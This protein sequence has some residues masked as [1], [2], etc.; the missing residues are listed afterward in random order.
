MISRFISKIT[1]LMI[2]FCFQLSF[3]QDVTVDFEGRISNDN[4]SL[5]EAI[6]QVI[7]NGKVLT[8]FKTDK[9]GSYNVYLP[10]GG[11]YIISV[12]KNDYVKKYFS[13]STTGIPPEKAKN[14]FP[15]IEADVDL[16]K[17][18]EGVDY[19]LFDQPVNKYFYNSKRDNIDYD[20]SYL[21]DMVAA[22]KKIKLAEKEA[23]Q[24][25]LQKNAQKQL[26]LKKL[27]NQK[28]EADKLALEKKKLEERLAYEKEMLRKIDAELLANKTPTAPV[29]EKNDFK[30]NIVVADP[31]DSKKI[32]DKK[33]ADLL[34][35]Y[36]QGVTEEQMEGEGIIIIKR[37]VVREQEAWV[38]EKRIFN[39]GGVSYFRDRQPITAG[40][41]EQETAKGL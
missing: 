17:Y 16:F 6:V 41:F 21:K 30:L 3:G 31:V 39:W 33:I 36:K 14:K 34:A 5:S 27:A 26:E 32:I 10:L 25:A 4:V 8:S 20:K 19:S 2:L 9:D 15:I 40:I 28:E 38:Y 37:T 22:M 29:A 12:S 11:D 18:Y 24:L 13:V 7:Q 1:A 23:I 35:K